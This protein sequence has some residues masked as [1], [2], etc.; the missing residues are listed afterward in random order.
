MKII[1]NLTASAGLSEV[2]IDRKNAMEGVEAQFVSK[3]N[4][5]RSLWAKEHELVVSIFPPT[6]AEKVIRM[7]LE[8]LYM[9]HTVGLEQVMVRMKTFS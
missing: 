8:R 4:Q 2:S 5:L 3:V 6:S 1:L 9:D 7:I